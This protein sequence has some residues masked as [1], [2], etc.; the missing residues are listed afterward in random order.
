MKHALKI[1]TLLTLP[2]LATA[3]SNTTTTTAPAPKISGS[4]SIVG[5]PDPSSTTQTDPTRS[6]YVNSVAGILADDA[7]RL[8]MTE[9]NSMGYYT[10]TTGANHL[11]YLLQYAPTMANIYYKD[12]DG[13][14]QKTSG[15]NTLKTGTTGAGVVNIKTGVKGLVVADKGYA[16]C[17]NLPDTQDNGAVNDATFVDS[18]RNTLHLDTILDAK[19]LKEDPAWTS[20]ATITNVINDDAHFGKNCHL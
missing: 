13:K 5:S 18:T 9:A 3:C 19:P 8:I 1:V 6:I 15:G 10:P 7:A 4:S 17:I 11:V 20:G 16:I 2:V 12:A 14:L